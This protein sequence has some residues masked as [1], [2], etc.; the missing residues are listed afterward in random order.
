MIG[1]K[2]CNVVCLQENY[3][4]KY[5]YYHY[6]NWPDLLY[7]AEDR[8]TGKIVGY[9]MAKIDDPED[10][11][12]NKVKGHITSLSVRREYRRM[13]IAAKLMEQTHKAMFDVFGVD[14]VTLH[15]R[16]TNQ[17]ALGLY[18]DRLKYDVMDKDKGYYLDG[19][20]AYLMKKELVSGWSEIN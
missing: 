17:A 1:I 13:G 18:R 16:E 11:D 6:L 3:T 5:Y 14:I 15:V 8:K 10:S 12:L 19:E 2:E 4:F 20:D 9:V 7:V